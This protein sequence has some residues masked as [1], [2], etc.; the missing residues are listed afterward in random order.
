MIGLPGPFRYF[1]RFVPG[2]DGMQAVSRLAVPALLFAAVLAALGLQWLSRTGL[3][4]LRTVLTVAACVAVLAELYVTPI[5]HPVDTSDA[6]TATYERLERLAPGAV[7]ELPIPVPGDDAA[8]PLVEGPRMLASIGDWRPRVNGYSGAYPD[9]YADLASVLNDFPDQR[10][11]E[12]LRADGVRHVVIHIGDRPDRSYPPEI[13][14]AMVDDLPPGAT[15]EMAG[16]T[17]LVTL[18]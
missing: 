3:P 11:L 17:W 14:Q 7:V 2:F 8:P 1:Y 12:Q 4:G 16:S 15:V 13:A 18:P 10:A 6:T 9:G 5:R